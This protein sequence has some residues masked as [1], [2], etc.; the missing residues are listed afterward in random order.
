MDPE[1]VA[2]RIADELARL[3]SE[4]RVVGVP[5]DR[6]TDFVAT[7]PATD[8]EQGDDWILSY[9]AAGATADVCPVWP[10]DAR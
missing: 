10:L 4:T 6:G 7:G 2:H 5:G 8:A 3:G 9:T 1:C